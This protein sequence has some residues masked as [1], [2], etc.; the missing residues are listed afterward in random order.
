MN[1]KDRYIEQLEKLI[2]NELLPIYNKYYALKGMPRPELSIPIP[3][4][5]RKLPAI[6][7]K[8]V[9]DI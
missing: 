1:D 9:S 7:Q 6:L 3:R 8:Q 5:P 4:S 2:L